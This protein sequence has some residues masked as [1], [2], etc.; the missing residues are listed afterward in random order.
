MLLCDSCD[1]GFHMSCCNPKETQMP[2]GIFL[3]ILFLIFIIFQFFIFHLH[4][5][6]VWECEICRKEHL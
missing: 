3:F 1:R 6:G 5:L 4:F 2:E